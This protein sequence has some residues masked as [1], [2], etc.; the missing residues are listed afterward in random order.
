MS[1][2]CKLFIEIFIRF[3]R[4]QKQETKTVKS[5]SKP[6]RDD[7]Y[8]MQCEEQVGNTYMKS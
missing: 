8:L 1:Q 3:K 4:G 7:R 6:I 5:K 2:S